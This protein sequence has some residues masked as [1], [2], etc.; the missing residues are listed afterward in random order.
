[1]QSNIGHIDFFRKAAQFETDLRWYAIADSAQHNALPNAIAYESPNV[2][3]LLGATQGSPLAQQSPHLVELRSP[4]EKTKSW[5]WVAINAHSKPC[6]SIIASMKSFDELF[7]QLTDFVEIVLPDSDAMY[8]AFWDPAILG[9]LMGQHDDETLY[10]KGPVFD[11]QQRAKI[12][13]GVSGWWYWDRAGSIHSIKATGADCQQLN[14]PVSLSQ[15]QVDDLVEASVPDHILYYVNLNQAHLLVEVA[16]EKRYSLISHAL[17]RARGLGLAGMR[18]LVNY[19]C[20]ELIYK[21]RMHDEA[22]QRIF[23]NVRT[24]HI[25]FNAALDQ[26]P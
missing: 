23:E 13:R 11:V 4:S 16:S 9:T 20:V 15:S 19:V 24:G 5:S 1:M 8:L 10:V 22:I 21:E 26:L 17:A 18:D 25:Q 2:R 12:M 6:I 7:D 14:N 3:C